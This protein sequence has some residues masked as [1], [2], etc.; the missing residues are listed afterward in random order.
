MSRPLCARLGLLLL[1]A[2][3]RTPSGRAEEQ[4]PLLQTH[5]QTSGTVTTNVWSFGRVFVTIEGKSAEQLYLL[6]ARNL[7]VEAGRVDGPG[8][9][10]FHE[11]TGHRPS[12]FGD[13]YYCQLLV[14]PGGATAD[15]PGP[16]A[17]DPGGANGAGI[18]GN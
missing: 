15:V 1:L 6:L 8:I 4:P 17:T 9:T 14:E 10:C 12:R 5:A 13:V 18:G 16:H 3:G 11:H 2:L 7:P